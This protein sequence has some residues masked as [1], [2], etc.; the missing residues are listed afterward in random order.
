MQI[1]SFILHPSALILWAVVL[2]QDLRHRRIW[3][4]ALAALAV[5]GLIGQAW[6]WWLV[7]GVALMWPKRES[8]LM[9]AAMAIGLSAVTGESAAGVAI[10]A[11]AAAWALGWWGGADSILL[12]ALGLRYGW[13]GIIAGA[14]FAAGLGLAVM[15]ARGRSLRVMPAV[16][17]E[18]LSLQAREEIDVPAEAEMPAAVALAAAGL[19]L[20]VAGW[21]GPALS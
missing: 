4:I 18:A 11:G 15:I 7:A 14:L 5:T 9:L 6:P 2:I 3:L 13:P 12:M 8:A 17:I 1:I 20:E 21:L 16:L 19:L 10:A